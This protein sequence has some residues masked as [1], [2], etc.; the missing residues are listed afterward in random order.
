MQG[1][2]GKAI[3]TLVG[4]DASTLVPLVRNAE[5][6]THIQKLFQ[7]QRPDDPLG[8]RLYVEPLAGELSVVYAFDTPEMLEFATADSVARLR[9][10]PPAL[11]KLAVDNLFDRIGD[12]VN[13]EARNDGIHD[14]VADGTFESSLLLVDSLWSQE[15]FQLRGRPVVFVPARHV[16]LVVGSEDAAALGAA[17]RIVQSQDWTHP[18]SSRAFER[19]VNVWC[20]RGPDL[21]EYVA[22]FLGAESALLAR[23]PDAYF[24][25]PFV[26]DRAVGAIAGTPMTHP[27][28]ATTFI[29][30]DPDYVRGFSFTC[31]QND[32]IVSTVVRALSDAMDIFEQAGTVQTF[33]SP[34]SYRLVTLSEAGMHMEKVRNSIWGL[35]ELATGA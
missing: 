34:V 21:K 11:R 13:I 7:E 3:A 24:S 28:N 1:A 27:A 18:L 16:L 22:A 30:P 5:W 10:D 20:A 23:H 35:P 19:A 26:L 14:V 25:R 9:L 2:S 29:F 33:T 4:P 32:E 15:N 12:D 6:I 17:R 31:Y 8:G